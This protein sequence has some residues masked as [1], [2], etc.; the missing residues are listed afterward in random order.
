MS[1]TEQKVDSDS[2]HMILSRLGGSF[3]DGSYTARLL[4][5]GNLESSGLS[6]LESWS[7]AVFESIRR[8]QSLRAKEP[9]GDHNV[10]VEAGLQKAGAWAET[11]DQASWVQQVR[12]SEENLGRLRM[13]RFETVGSFC[14]MP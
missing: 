8:L 6:G 13:V 11:L 3:N 2:E 5:R 1:M 9:R 12:G 10:A 4:K 7:L 14:S